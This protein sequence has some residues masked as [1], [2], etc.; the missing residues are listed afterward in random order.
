MINRSVAREI[1]AIHR[2][3]KCVWY[4]Q[5]KYLFWYI[6]KILFF[7]CFA[8]N[9]FG[10]RFL[11]G[12][13]VYWIG[14]YSTCRLCRKFLSLQSDIW[15]L[16]KEDACNPNTLICAT[17]CTFV[18]VLRQ[19]SSFAAV[20]CGIPSIPICL[21]MQGIESWRVLLLCSATNAKVV[22]QSA[23]YILDYRREDS[24]MRGIS[25]RQ[26]NDSVLR[27]GLSLSLPRT[28]NTSARRYQLC[29][30]CTQH[31]HRTSICYWWCFVHKLRCSH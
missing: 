17:A 14:F 30:A 4:G 3:V 12:G 18:W 2:S 11:L 21:D 26:T 10:T 20:A 29:N 15:G 19:K 23:S 28:R 7:A 27:T 13:R 24:R 25:T 31:R 8:F 9:L 6:L 1:S 22:L 5:L 16:N